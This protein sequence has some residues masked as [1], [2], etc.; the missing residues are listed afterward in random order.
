[1]RKFTLR[2]AA[3]G[4]AFASL[5]AAQPALAATTTDSF[6]VRLTIL[7][8]CE[9]AVDGGSDI[10]LDDWV[11]GA[12]VDPASGSFSVSCSKDTPYYIGLLPQNTGG[13][14]GGAGRLTGTG[15]NTDWVAYQLHKLS[16]SGGAWGNTASLGS[17]GNGVG[18]LGSGVST[19]IPH[20]VFATV[21]SST[22]V[23]PDEYTDTVLV[24]VHF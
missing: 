21:E 12:T 14:D 11:A 22:D 8:T 9:I 2:A 5:A 24:T 20:E 4:L 10:E 1:M 18:G 17:V 23:L 7:E 19:A 15:G 6:D 16:A 13:T 3:G